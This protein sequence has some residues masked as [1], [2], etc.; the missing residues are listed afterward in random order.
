MVIAVLV[1]DVNRV[2]WNQNISPQT[3]TEI[4]QYQEGLA[5]GEQ[6][7]LLRKAE[8]DS[9]QLSTINMSK[10]ARLWII[11]TII[12]IVIAFAFGG[13]VNKIYQVIPSVVSNIEKSIQNRTNAELDRMKEKRLLEQQ[14]REVEKEKRVVEEQKMLAEKEAL[15]A[16]LAFL[17]SQFDPHFLYNTLN[18]F[19]AET[20][21]SS[22]KVA[23]GIMK[24]SD[25]MR[26]SLNESQDSR[27]PL[28][29]EVHYLKNYIDIHQLRFSQKLSI[30]F[31]VDGAVE[32]KYI[33]PLVL[34]SFVENAFKH[35]DLFS[36]SVPLKIL[37][38]V[39][40]GEISFFVQN[41]KRADKNL[42]STGVGLENIR[43]RLSLAYPNQ[44]DL[45]ITEDDEI[46]TS[47]LH[48]YQNQSVPF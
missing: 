18:Y 29:E 8:L 19:Y 3:P 23:E 33:L 10:Y 31:R 22:S 7:A 9:H 37:L 11:F 43:R 26:Y 30:Q 14:Q 16:E 2:G 41:K 25:I 27:A 17:K 36:A 47:K 32:E 48:I 12:S 4:A 40:Q 21:K 44:H 28:S 1:F 24:L 38:S 5:Q 39:S 15:R 46:Y 45:K 20:R 13:T 42:S 6:W 34:I 35:G